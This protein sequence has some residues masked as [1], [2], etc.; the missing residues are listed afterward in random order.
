MQAAAVT[1]SRIVRVRSHT[2]SAPPKPRSVAPGR[3]QMPSSRVSQNQPSMAPAIDPQSTTCH[4]LVTQNKAQ[5]SAAMN[6][7]TCPGYI[8]S[9]VTLCWTRPGFHRTRTKVANASMREPLNRHMTQDSPPTA[10]QLK[11]DWVIDMGSPLHAD[12][13]RNAGYPGPFIN[14]NWLN[15][16]SQ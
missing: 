3:I 14:V 7:N 9:R 6:S 2:F 10:M 11:I 8:A 5:E 15:G 12:S 13:A 1:G 16:P 4:R